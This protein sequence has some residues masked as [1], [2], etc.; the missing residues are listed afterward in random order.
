MPLSPDT[1]LG[2]TALGLPS[3]LSLMKLQQIRLL[4][5]PSHN[6]LSEV[7]ASRKLRP[8]ER[9]NLSIK[10]AL[11]LQILK[12]PSRENVEITTVC[13]PAH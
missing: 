10:S 6:K 1:S 5:K 8:Q 11:F 13:R 7:P 12:Y 2:W 9:G 3:S 4:V